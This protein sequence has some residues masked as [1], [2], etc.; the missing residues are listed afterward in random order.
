MAPRTININN[1]SSENVAFFFLG[2]HRYLRTKMKI[3]HD[4]LILLIEFLMDTWY[5]VLRNRCLG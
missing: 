1:S 4:V 2:D 3:H 5:Q